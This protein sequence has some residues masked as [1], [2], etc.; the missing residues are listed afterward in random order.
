MQLVH[1]L[2]EHYQPIIFL[3]NVQR[4]FSTSITL[5]RPCIT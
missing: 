2:S 5:N 4:R 1:S 3:G